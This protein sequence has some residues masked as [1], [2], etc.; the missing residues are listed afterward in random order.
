MTEQLSVLFVCTGNVCRSPYAERRAASVSGIHRFASAG[1]HALVGSLMDAHMAQ[2]ARLRGAVPDGFVA[3]QLTAELAGSADLILTAEVGQRRWV[4]G[5][6]PRLTRRIFT[7]GQFAALVDQG[8]EG[9]TPREVIHD[10]ARR[11]TAALQEL[12]VP[13]PYRKGPEAARECAD[14]LDD[15]L[16]RIFSRLG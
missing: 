7:I 4:L 10:A 11:R 1:T 12:D 8:L 3:K 16:T 9:L 2:E 13:D 14:L 15:H 6:W 5:D